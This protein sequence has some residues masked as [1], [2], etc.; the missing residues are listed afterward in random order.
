[1]IPV[2]DPF[3]DPRDVMRGREVCYEEVRLRRTSD[4]VRVME[5][6]LATVGWISDLHSQLLVASRDTLDDSDPQKSN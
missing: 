1:M 6:I 2:S 5:E 4:R 3:I